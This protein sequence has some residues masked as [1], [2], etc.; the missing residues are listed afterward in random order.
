[1]SHWSSVFYSLTDVVTLCLSGNIYHPSGR[2]HVNVLTVPYKMSLIK[3]EPG[4]YIQTYVNIRSVCNVLLIGVG[5]SESLCL[6]YYFWHT[7]CLRYVQTPT[8]MGVL[9]M[10]ILSRRLRFILFCPWFIHTFTYVCV[11]DSGAL[12][13]T[14]ALGTY[15][16]SLAIKGSILPEE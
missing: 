6:T 1:M 12:M 9:Y 5:W 15:V 3:D 11:R 14:G 7:W 13:T 2:L 16:L 4:I 10:Y 8:Y